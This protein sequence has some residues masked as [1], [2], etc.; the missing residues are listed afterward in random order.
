MG[1]VRGTTGY[2]SFERFN[3]PGGYTTNLHVPGGANS[4]VNLVHNER[5]QID[6]ILNSYKDGRI[7]GNIFFLNPHGIIIGQGGVVNVGSL[8]LQTPTQDYMRQL[9]NEHAANKFYR[10]FPDR[11]LILYAR[12]GNKLLPCVACFFPIL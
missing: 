1:T 5:S 4:L 6:G 10:V 11:P 3:V 7:G 8:H 12:N 9:I 2:S